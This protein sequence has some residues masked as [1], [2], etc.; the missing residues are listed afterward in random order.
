MGNNTQKDS[1]LKNSRV[2]MLTIALAY[3]G[4]VSLAIGSV[5]LGLAWPTMH[6]EFGV[7]LANQGILLVASI[8][9][10][11]IASFASGTVASRIGTGPL[12]LIGNLITAGCLIAV[13]LVQS[14]PLLIMCF[15][16][17]GVGRGAIDA[18]VN[19]YMA[20]NFGGRVMN[21]LH[22]AYGIGVTI[23]PLIMSAIFA[24]QLSWRYGYMIA[25]ICA[26]IMA[27]LFLVTQ[28]YWQNTKAIASDALSDAEVRIPTQPLAA[29][30]RLPILWLGLLMV[31]LYAGSEGTPSNW[32]YTLF[33]QGR[34]IPEVDAAQWVSIYGG[35]F[36]F[37]RFFFGF[38]IN[39][40]SASMLLRG[41]AIGAMVGA[42]LLWWNPVGWVAFAG[43]VLLGFTQA[44]VFP[45]LVSNM[46]NWVGKQHAANAIG[47]QVAFAGA[48]FTLI[49]ALTGILGQAI[50]L[51]V[52]P[53][54]IFFCVLIFLG[55]YQLSEVIRSRS[56]KRKRVPAALSTN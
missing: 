35:T 11:L 20:Q 14:W 12:L 51:E 37:G 13:A 10:S 27:V 28:K 40:I 7:Q 8:I 46:P 21:W 29:T 44:P 19:A 5:V 42:G 17:Y 15:L 18:G 2:E 3:L 55:L 32:M 41:C 56:E 38:I 52:I 6:L 22:A 34:A 45:V 16:L 48:G 47:F 50:S 49:P 39:R 4:F 53:A 9:G 26:G 31:L 30:L 25:S 23:T 24:A 1:M 33:T 54:V 36:T 43:L